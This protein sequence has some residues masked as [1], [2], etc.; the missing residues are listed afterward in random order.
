[1]IDKEEILK[2]RAKQLA[3]VTEV[4]DHSKGYLRVIIFMLAHEQ[5]ALEIPYVKEVSV[6]KEYTALPCVPSFI[7]GLINV[8][9]KVI[10]VFDL[11]QYFSLPDS[12]SREKKVIIVEQGEMEF[13]LLA[14]AVVGVQEIALSHIEAPLPTLTG[15]R[16]EFLKGVTR[17]GVTVLDGQK[18]L[19]SQ[20]IIV[21]DVVEIL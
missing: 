1:M 8:R 11:K 14:D 16:Q 18:L 17:Q 5:Y 6:Y 19:S 15:I 20:R 3:Q 12:E 13:A 21:N 2:K 10:S 4:Q 9:R 7:S